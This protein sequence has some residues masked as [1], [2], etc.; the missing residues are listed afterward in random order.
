MKKIKK[1]EYYWEATL[2]ITIT[3]LIPLLCAIPIAA[4]I[5]VVASII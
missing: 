2:E 1:F 5:A 4:F 3:I